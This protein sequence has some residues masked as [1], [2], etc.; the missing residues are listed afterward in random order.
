MPP[1][2]RS[3]QLV[4]QKIRSRKAVPH[5]LF[6]QT[7]P[8]ARPRA[9]RR[10]LGAP[11]PPRRRGR[12]QS[13]V[14]RHARPREHQR[15][16]QRERGAAHL[17]GPR[18]RDDHLVPARDEFAHQCTAEQSEIIEMSVAI[19]RNGVDLGSRLLEPQQ[20]IVQHLRFCRKIYCSKQEKEDPFHMP[21]RFG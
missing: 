10:A 3:A 9:P 7:K 13:S 11:G 6:A 15:P 21:V 12:K 2:R 4:P 14:G 17:R 8:R 16:A 20:G 5:V 1:T 19:R 18:R